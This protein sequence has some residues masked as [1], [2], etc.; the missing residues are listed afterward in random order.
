[1]EW[2]DKIGDKLALAVSRLIGELSFFNVGKML[3]GR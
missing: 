1:M 3:T 2:I